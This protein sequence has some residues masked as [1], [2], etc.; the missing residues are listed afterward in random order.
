[1][2]FTGT[3]FQ[4]RLPVTC[5][6]NIQWTPAS[7]VT[8]ADLQQPVLGPDATIT[9]RVNLDYGFCVASDTIHITVAD[10]DELDCDNIFFPSGFTPNA[11]NLNDDWGMSNIVFLGEF[12]SLQVFDRWGGEVYFSSDPSGRW[13]GTSRGKDIMPGLYVYQ[14]TYTC[15]G[16]ERH[17]TG[18]VTLIK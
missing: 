18:A 8:T 2:L 16:E 15:D 13:D 12:V 6:D 5:A 10:P 17:K 9:Y 3:S 11:D 4:V 7:G 14:F 1:V